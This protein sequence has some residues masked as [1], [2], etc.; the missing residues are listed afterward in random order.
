MLR[1]WVLAAQGEGEQGIAQIRQGLSTWQA[2]GAEMA[3]PHWL[4]LLAEGYGTAGR[5]EE[6]LPLLTEALA[7]VKHTGEREYE[8]ELY[9]LK[10]QLMLQQFQVS[11]S[12]FQVQ[13]NQKSKI[14][15]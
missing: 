8:A 11:G 5:A 4:A 3:R 6:G 10:G 14:K 2:M 15:N 1:G 13:E 7:V 9:R 12:K